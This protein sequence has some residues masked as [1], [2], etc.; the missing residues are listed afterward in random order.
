MAWLDWEETVF[1]GL[2]ALHARAVLRPR[3]RA[4]AAVEARLAELRGPL[5]FFAQ[6]LAGR[7]VSLFETPNQVLCDRERVFLPPRFSEAEEASLNVDFYWLKTALAALAIRR[8]DALTP[9]AVLVEELETL[10]GLRDVL[11]RVSD[12]LGEARLWQW[13]GK[14]VPGAAPDATTASS[15]DETP[16][17]GEGAETPATEV[18]GKGQTEVEVRDGGDDAAPQADMPCH[19][20]EKVEALEEYGGLPRRSDAEDELAEH[21]DALR[22]L[23]MKHLV[24]T[25]ERPRSIYR[26]DIALDGCG[27]EVDDAPAGG[28]LP[29]PEWNYKARSYRPAWC[30]VREVDGE[31]G[32][33][34]WLAAVEMRRRGLV[35]DLKKHF[36]AAANEW[37]A[38]RRQPIGAE[39]D[40]DAVVAAEVARRLGQVADERHY[41]DRRRKL[42][43]V[44]A[45]ILLDQS[46]STDAWLDETR[47]LDTMRETIFCV[48]EVLDEFVERFAV[49]AFHSNTRRDC[50][51]VWLK[52]FEA[53][54]R[55]KRT[56][57]GGLTPDGYTR[58]GP[59]L[60]HA[61]RALG[62]MPAARRVVILVTDGR[63]CDY[64]RYEG[65]YGIRDVA[66]A[67]EE[68][69]QQGVRT[70]AF[71]ID[72]RAREHFPRMFRDCSYHVVP[73]PTALVR[74]MC[75]LFLRLEAG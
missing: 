43:D 12:G 34:A 25:R 68:G 64:D 67:I 60:R 30:H 63:P 11:T 65:E 24:R 1:N 35:L 47:I 37:L 75:D 14:A 66:R 50:R 32:D 27:L 28:G 53:S 16:E 4:R 9:S 44:A 59:A 21:E 41:V 49:A 2:R 57:L 54:W 18:E 55:Q 39:F 38:S 5:F 19:T 15:H 69:R 48:G 40:L 61:H 52:R 23:D 20:F 7:P 72:R 56:H 22:E 6:M 31:T 71:A 17:Q 58:I 74:S 10:P 26:G 36:A 45:L 42:H 3:Q 73:Q 29:Y 46:L 8:G 13:L 51:F 62:R 33:A 70:H